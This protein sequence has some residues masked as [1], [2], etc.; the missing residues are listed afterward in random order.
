MENQQTYREK[1]GTG[2]EEGSETGEAG[3]VP[4][5]RAFYFYYREGQPVIRC[6]RSLAE[7][8][9][10][11][12]EVDPT[13]VQFHV[14]RGDFDAWLRSIGERSL[15]NQVAALR[16]RHIPA[17]ELRI[18]VGLAVASC[19]SEQ[20]GQRRWSEHGQTSQGSAQQRAEDKSRRSSSQ[21]SSSG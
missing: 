19:I 1:Q 12:R 6:S 13:S 8:A 4:Q 9:A 2:S 11:I 5:D 16:G 20:Q 3:R 14:E 7:F 10:S 21:S 18:E 15:A 17:E